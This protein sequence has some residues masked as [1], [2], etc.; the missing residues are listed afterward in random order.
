M[1][2]KRTAGRRRPKGE[3]T[4]FKAKDG[5]RAAY[6][7]VNEDG[8]RKRVVMRAP[9][10]AHARER[11][12]EVKRRA[13]Q[14]PAKVIVK[15]SVEEH[16]LR[17]LERDRVRVKPSTYQHRRNHVVKHL[18]PA[19]GKVRLDR[20]TPAMVEDMTT[21]MLVT[22]KKPLSPRTVAHI[23]GTLRQALNAAMRDG[24]V[25]SNAAA[26]AEPPRQQHVEMQ[27]LSARQVGRLLAS[28]ET[29]ATG[30]CGR[31]W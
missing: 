6:T 2:R 28:T 21:E 9:D 7:V 14:N 10:E 4:T 16:L 31:C 24:L 3:G 18:V 8:T 23:R 30:R 22:G 20:L 19:I 27:T 17:W 26:L 15:D 11:L 13:K 5:W 25:T 12:E 1:P 29:T